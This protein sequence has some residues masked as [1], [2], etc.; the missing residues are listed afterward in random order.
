MSLN[1]C[2]HGL[3][4]DLNYHIIY[5][6]ISMIDHKYMYDYDLFIWYLNYHFII[7]DGRA[8]VIVHHGEYLY[9]KNQQS[10]IY[11]ENEIW[12][13]EISQFIYTTHS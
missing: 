5:A 6:G 1:I 10:F 13:D 8:N 11:D 12:T 4:Y 2:L 9:D 7:N 3:N